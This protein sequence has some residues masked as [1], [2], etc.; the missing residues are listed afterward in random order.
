MTSRSFLKKFFHYK[1]ARLVLVFF[2][3]FWIPRIYFFCVEKDSSTSG[4]ALLSPIFL[5]RTLVLDLGFIGYTLLPI[6]ILRSFL[7]FTLRFTRG[8]E[9][10]V[11]FALLSSTFGEPIFMNDLEARFNFI[12]VD[13]IVYTHEVLSNI[14]QSYPIVWLVSGMGLIFVGLC[15]LIYRLG[16]PVSIPL[17]E[18]GKSWKRR[19]LTAAACALL[20]VGSHFAIT[21][22]RLIAD[23]SMSTQEIA[24]N[25]TYALFAAYGNN[26]LD[27]FRFY[28][29]LTPEAAMEFENE[30]ARKPKS[31]GMGMDK[32]LE[33]PFS[34]QPNVVLV[35]MES[36]SASFLN[37]YGGPTDLTPNLD[38]L[39]KEGVWFSNLFATGTRTVRGIEAVM[40]SLP[41]APGYSIV[42]RPG[43]AG[44][45]N[46]GTE[47]Q[48][49]G[50]A[51]SFVYGG[52][53]IFD[54]MGPFF[55]SNGFDI[56]DKGRF[57][58]KEQTFSTAWGLCDED[59]FNKTIAEGDRLHAEKKP[60]FQFLLTTSNHRPYRYPSGKVA[61]ASGSVRQGAV[62]YSDYSI[63]EFLK[64]VRTRPWFNDTIFLFISDHNASVAGG[65][66]VIPR[67]Y[68]VPVIFYAPGH[69]R[70]TNVK[71]LASQVD[72]GPTLFDILGWQFD[73]KRFFGSSIISHPTQEAFFGNYQNIGRMRDSKFVLLKPKKRIEEFAVT[74]DLKLQDPKSTTSSTLNPEVQETISAYSVAYRRYISGALRI[75]N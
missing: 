38:R 2:L 71:E 50:Y 28:R 17:L 69:L 72:L 14:W 32:I 52:R 54:N 73:E 37:S 11:L 36:M 25:G 61:I 12:A 58:E 56:V 53:G 41:P 59:L 5:L 23:A 75:K 48:R 39:T 68:L 63:G 1:E 35:L 8:L 64:N 67:D 9:G 44:I 55:A 40:L 7:P 6:W 47:F 13:Y 16:K 74:P 15:F 30:S 62:Q 65:S 21:E 26:T 31:V 42:G 43:G 24:K 34:K 20:T 45:Y 51:T 70:P 4:L 66:G 3:L 22:D 57:E 29:S 18:T 19:S 46:L 49:R 10:L 60:F 33:K 27:F